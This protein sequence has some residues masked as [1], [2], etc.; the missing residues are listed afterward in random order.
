MH[1]IP[2]P[3]QGYLP[4]PMHKPSVQFYW[5]PLETTWVSPWDEYYHTYPSSPHCQQE[6]DRWVIAPLS[7]SSWVLVSE[8]GLV[9]SGDLKDRWVSRYPIP[10]GECYE[11]CTL[12]T[13]YM[14]SLICHGADRMLW[15]LFPWLGA[16]R[17]AHRR[18]PT[19]AN[20]WP[21][22]RTH[23]TLTLTRSYS[24]RE[25]PQPSAEQGATS[26]GVLLHCSSCSLFFL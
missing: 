14:A 15:R 24:I 6:T 17:L 13:R 21:M 2:A 25:K 18:E 26:F 22:E 10:L 5:G 3:V 19:C 11:P 12:R 4:L 16:N 7:N 9:G 20:P 8:G 23:L 1:Q